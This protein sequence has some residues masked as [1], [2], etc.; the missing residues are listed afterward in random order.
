[1]FVPRGTI[2]GDAP[3][4]TFG[5]VV[6]SGVI[7]TVG[8]VVTLVSGY[9]ENI[10]DTGEPVLGVAAGTVTGNGTNKVQVY[11]DPNLIFYNDSD[12]TLAQTDVGKVYRTT[13][14]KKIDQSTGA[15]NTA[16]AFVLVGVDPD[17]DADASKGLFKIYRSQLASNQLDA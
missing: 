15:V 2:A 17:G 1:M 3:G 7:V 9:V 13:A 12:G 11:T 6:S 4:A 8:N 14:S 16:Y 10:A 5:F